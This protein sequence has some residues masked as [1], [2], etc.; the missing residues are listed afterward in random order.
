MYKCENF[1][2]HELV[3]PKVYQKRGEKAWELLDPRLLI[4]L[5]RLRERYGPI[6][7]NDYGYRNPGNRQWSWLRT[8]GSPHFSPTSQHTFGRAA[9]C[10]FSDVEV[11]QVRKDILANPDDHAFKLINSIEL[12]VSWLHVDVRNCER[13]KAFKP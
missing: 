4:T 8:P 7:V 11:E 1:A 3:P 12:D 13:I 2:I 6:R 9:D 10:L 5:D